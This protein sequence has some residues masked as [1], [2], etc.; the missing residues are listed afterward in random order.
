MC[1]M[2]PIK[3][4]CLLYSQCIFSETVKCGKVYVFTCR[5]IDIS[6]LLHE[7][8][9]GHFDLQKCVS[10]LHGLCCFI[11]LLLHSDD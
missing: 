8:K 6:C 9:R 3:G 2:N 7:M 10:L 5:R 1:C 4:Q 11:L